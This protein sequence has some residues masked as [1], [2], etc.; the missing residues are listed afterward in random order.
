MAPCALTLIKFSL[1][2]GMFLPSILHVTIFSHDRS[3]IFR[4]IPYSERQTSPLSH[5]QKPKSGRFSTAFFLCSL[6]GD[7]KGKNSLFLIVFF[8]SLHVKETTVFNKAT[9]TSIINLSFLL[10]QLITWFNYK[11]YSRPLNFTTPIY[12]TLLAKLAITP[13]DV[14]QPLNT[15]VRKRRKN[16]CRRRPFNCQ[17]RAEDFPSVFLW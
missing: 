15:S 11:T 4:Y 8:I 13:N 12:L 16:R 7:K 9:D 5:S 10:Q 1:C 6:T 3:T 14:R 17:H 2:A